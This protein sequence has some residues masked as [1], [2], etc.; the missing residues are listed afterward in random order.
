[1]RARVLCL[2]L[3][4]FAADAFAAKKDFKGLFGSYR[5]EKFTENEGRSTDFGL[6]LMLSTLLPVT[7]MVT[8]SEANAAAQP[9]YYASY[10]NAEA[11]FFFTLNYHWELF[12][13]VGY[14]TYSTRK[15]NA[16]SS[17][18]IGTPQYHVFDMEAIPAILGVKYRFGTSDI[19]PYI[20]AGAGVA[21]VH[22]RSTYDYDSTVYDDNYSTAIVAQATAGVQ[23]YISPR[24]GI[25][26]EAS[27]MYMGLQARTFDVNAHTLIPVM[28]Y[29]ANP[30]AVRYSSGLFILF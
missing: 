25:R 23:F 16:T 27:A 14:Y 6:D 9:L 12:A 19:V 22:R 3:L 28:N 4:C 24:T 18:T 7:N 21:Y 20:G 11:A 29:V 15:Q 1:M 13:N 2:L 30:I 5:R 8:S 17:S 26:L 10:F